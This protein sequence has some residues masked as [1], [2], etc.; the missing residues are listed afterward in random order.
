[1][2]SAICTSFDSSIPFARSLTMIRQAGFEVISI[3]GRP[4]RSG[5]AT[6]AGRAAIRERMAMHGLAVDSVHAPFPEGDRLFSLDE[7]ERLKSIRQCQTALDAAAELAGRMVVV[8]LIQPYD[9]P[10]GDARDR[11][12][13][14]GRR[15]V[16]TLADYAAK[17]GVKLALENGQRAFYD[18]VLASFLTE[19]D[20]PHVGFCYDSGHEHVQGTCFRL[21]ERFGHRLLTLHVHDNKGTDTHVLPHEGTIDW[22]GFRR[23]LHGLDYAG[24]LLL[25]A[26]IRNS[27]IKDPAIFLAEAWKCAEELRQ[28]PDGACG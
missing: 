8:H 25:E 5:Y 13:D 11:M 23:T 9:I 4:E 10:A 12:V 19:F 3:G 2:K 24:N 22:E 7:A 20:V 26:D 17:A 18:G 28:P 14:H 6:V 15:S 27:S 21:L 1:M 16:A